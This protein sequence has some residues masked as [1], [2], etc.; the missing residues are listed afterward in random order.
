M[1]KPIDASMERPDTGE[2][3]KVSG[4]RLQVLIQAGYPLV[5][6][7]QLAESDADLHFCEEI[8]ERGCDPRTA[9]AILL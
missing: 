4:W 3:A 1:P 9:A 2:H 8:L 5:L 6:A 7:E